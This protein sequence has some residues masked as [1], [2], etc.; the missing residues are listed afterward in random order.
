MDKNLPA[1]A[2]DTGSIPGPERLHMPWSKQ[3]H[4]PQV[5]SV[6]APATEGR[7]PGACA[8]QQEQ[9]PQ[10]EACT[11]HQGVAPARCNYRK[12]EHS[13][14]DPVQWKRN[15][16]LFFFLFKKK[17]VSTPPMLRP[18]NEAKKMKPILQRRMVFQQGPNY[19]L[20]TSTLQ[21]NHL[22]LFWFRV[23]WYYKRPHYPEKYING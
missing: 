8:P 22:W 21:R 5:P 6:P 17:D 15:R 3:A 12:P 4:E 20:P 1:S 16:F 2:E 7:V 9:S 14:K 10:G 11:P 13:S 19:Y 23:L 18:A